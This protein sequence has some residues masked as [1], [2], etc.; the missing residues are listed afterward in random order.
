MASTYLK[1]GRGKFTV[2][3]EQKF[4]NSYQYLRFGSKTSDI[5]VYLY[6]KSTELKQ[7]Q[8][9]PYIRKL[10]A[11]NGI[12]D[13][14]T[15]WRLE[16]SIKGSGAHMVNLNT[17]E[18]CEIGFS[19]FENL[20]TLHDIYFSYINQHFHFKINDYTKNKSRMNQLVLFDNQRV[21]FK[22]LYLPNETG[23]NKSDKVF[24][25]KLYQLDQEIRGFNDDSLNSQK[26]IIADFIEATGL[27]EYVRNRADEW[28]RETPRPH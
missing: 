24:I 26:K 22:P 6:D 23:S 4:E 14:K 8:D 25:K 11:L 19:I 20:D 5:N 18:Q 15:V 16:V 13:Q 10:W 2:I 12:D 28:T 7:I 9:K 17:G 3:G 27:H 21:S 1:N